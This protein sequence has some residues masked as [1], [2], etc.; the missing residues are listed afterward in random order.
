MKPFSKCYY[1]NACGLL[2][3]GLI[4]TGIS[5]AAGAWDSEKY[6]E[7]LNLKDRYFS[8]TEPFTSIR[9]TAD[10]AD[11]IVKTTDSDTCTVTATNMPENTIKVTVEDGKLCINTVPEHR[12]WYQNFQMGI[13]PPITT[14]T[15]SL[16]MTVYEQ[17]ELQNDIGN[18]TLQNVHADR[19]SLK[20]DTGDVDLQSITGKTCSVT[21]N[22]GNLSL[23]EVQIR[24]QTAIQQDT[25]DLELNDCTFHGSSTISTQIGSM[26][27]SDSEFAATA[28]TSDTGD[29]RLKDCTFYQ[30]CTIKSDV[31]DVKGSLLADVNNT[32][33]D[34]DSALGDVSINGKKT[35]YQIPNALNSITIRVDTGDIRLTTTQPD[36]S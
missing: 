3:A 35:G 25:G 28:I 13:N 27:L 5:V 19:I 17:V 1:L 30:V 23:Q 34:A 14:I 9:L 24:E 15:L 7:A 20:S 36:A 26:H 6:G 31:G 10:T 29:I 22:V 12:K 18:L 21:S 33:L 32:S 8:V 11:V 2:L 4:V 16:P